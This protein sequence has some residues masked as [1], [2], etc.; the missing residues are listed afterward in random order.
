VALIRL[1]GAAPN[2]WI[3]PGCKKPQEKIRLV[4][5]AN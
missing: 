2:F 5:G 3:T 1:D 4:L